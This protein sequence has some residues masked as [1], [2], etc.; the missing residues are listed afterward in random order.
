VWLDLPPDEVREQ[1][2]PAG[3]LSLALG[4][5]LVLTVV[6]GFFP[7]IATVFADASRVLTAAVGAG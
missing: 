6:I 7:A 4:I 1:A 5:T 3:S 2:A